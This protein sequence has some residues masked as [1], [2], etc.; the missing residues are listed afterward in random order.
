MSLASA[1]SRLRAAGSG[2][3]A[4][5]APTSSADSRLDAPGTR[6]HASCCTLR[7]LLMYARFPATSIGL[8]GR[9]AC[10]Q[11]RRMRRV[12]RRHRSSPVRLRR[13]LASVRAS[14]C[15]S[16]QRNQHDCGA[17]HGGECGQSRASPVYVDP[18]PSPSA[19]ADSD[20]SDNWTRT[21][22]FGLPGSIAAEPKLAGLLAL[23]SALQSA[24]DAS[25][26]AGG[27]R[28]KPLRI[29]ANPSCGNSA[30]SS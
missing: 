30:C 27:F 11:I 3:Q 10:A 9:S 24:R 21:A 19:F 1:R 8:G 13:N 29:S 16:G 12:R 18:H 22:A 17:A 6:K 7:G 2:S 14:R 26:L 28:T 25:G 15:E 5:L 20:L 4:R 23:R